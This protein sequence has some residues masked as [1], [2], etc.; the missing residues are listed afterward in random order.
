MMTTERSV[1]RDSPF[2]SHGKARH[3]TASRGNCCHSLLY[4]LS[5]PP[6]VFH[7]VHAAQEI[8]DRMCFMKS[9]G[10]EWA[11]FLMRSHLHV[12]TVCFALGLLGGCTARQDKEAVLAPTQAMF[13]GMAHRDA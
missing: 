1:Q 9:N 4:R 5:L 10:F 8:S 11:A 6:D 3:S 2:L 12:V 7:C 13:D